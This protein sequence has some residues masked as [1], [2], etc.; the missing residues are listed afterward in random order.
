MNIEA[1]IVWLLS[2][3][4][5]GGLPGAILGTRVF[6]DEL[7]QKPVYPCV[8]FSKVDGA[9]SYSHDGD[10]NLTPYRFQIDCFDLT[11]SGAVAI[12]DAIEEPGE[13]GGVSGFVGEIPLSPPAYI[14]GAFIDNASDSAEPALEQAGPR[15]KRQ[16]LDVTFWFTK[17]I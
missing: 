17:G 3:D 16:T 5:P 12:R 9:R 1:A 6:L 13:D 14:R 7:P 8:A 4:R 10:S 15:V 11:A 2:S